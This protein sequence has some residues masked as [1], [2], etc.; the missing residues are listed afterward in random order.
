MKRAFPELEAALAKMLEKIDGVVLDSGY[1]G[2]PIQMYLAGGIAV[3]YYCGTRFTGDVN[4]SFSRRVLLPYDELTIDLPS[5]EKGRPRF[6]Y[7]D[8]TYNPTLS[9]MHENYLDHCIEWEEVG[10]GASKIKLLLLSPLDLA[11]SKISRFTEQDQ[12]DILDLAKAGYFRPE[13]VGQRATEALSY[14]VGNTPAVKTS[15]KII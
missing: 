7:F 11:V 1:S 6:I 13:E 2:Q 12:Q 9:L 5:T 14:Y 4:A 3:N 8:Q 10:Y 15:I